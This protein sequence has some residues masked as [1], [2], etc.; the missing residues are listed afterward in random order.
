[1]ITYTS[2]NTSVVLKILY[3]QR[4]TWISYITYCVGYLCYQQYYI[5]HY[6]QYN[7]QKTYNYLWYLQYG[8]LMLVTW[9]WEKNKYIK[10]LRRSTFTR[11]Y[12][13]EP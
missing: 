3:L 2:F 7:L 10:K 11:D 13:R 1:M 4:N 5:L 12:I 9:N 8:L 6:L